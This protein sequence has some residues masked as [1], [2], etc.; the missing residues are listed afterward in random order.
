MVPSGA[1]AYRVLRR[2]SEYLHGEVLV[3]QQS[4]SSKA[5]L[6]IKAM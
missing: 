6:V 3:T 4:G 1:G 5:R 2:N